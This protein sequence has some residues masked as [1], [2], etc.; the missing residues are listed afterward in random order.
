[1]GLLNWWRDYNDNLNIRFKIQRQLEYIINKIFY[2]YTVKI[3]H[4]IGDK[5]YAIYVHFYVE[6]HTKEVYI[7]Y[8]LVKDCLEYIVEPIKPLIDY[9]EFVI[10]LPSD[11]SERELKKLSQDV[12]NKLHSIANENNANKGDLNV[13][14]KLF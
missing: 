1:M 8:E 9:N 3:R 6:T 11:A 10:L 4:I 12:V 13:N 7:A 2:E 5:V 14:T